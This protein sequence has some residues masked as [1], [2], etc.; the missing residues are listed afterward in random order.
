MMLPEL[1]E[2]V[3]RSTG[4]ETQI[5][6]AW[7][8]SQTWPQSNRHILRSLSPVSFQDT[9]TSTAVAFGNNLQSNEFDS[10]LKPSAEDLQEFLRSVSILRQTYDDCRVQRGEDHQAHTLR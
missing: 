9:G 10:L 6:V 7:N 1:L 2:L 4:A 8:V 3:F 5:N